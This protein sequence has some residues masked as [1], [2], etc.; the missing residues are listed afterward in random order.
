MGEF[1]RGEQTV[2]GHEMENLLRNTVSTSITTMFP[3]L[4]PMCFSPQGPSRTLDHWVGPVGIHHVVEDFRVLRDSSY[5]RAAAPRYS[6]AYESNDTL[7]MSSIL[8]LRRNQQRELMEDR[9]ASLHASSFICTAA[10]SKD[11]SLQYIPF[12]YT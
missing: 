6:S 11:Q 5:S 8:R 10:S 1:H 2:A 4:G 12:C 9:E 7:M 3:D